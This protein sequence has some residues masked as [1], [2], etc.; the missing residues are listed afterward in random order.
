VTV[1]APRTGY[2]RAEL[3]SDAV[4]HAVGLVMVLAAVPVL[5]TLATVLRGDAAA[6]T[7]AAI[8]GAALV[9]MIAFSAAYN[10]LGQHRWTG[11]LQR[12]D[13]SAIYVK[14]A[15]TY[16]PF[17]ILPGDGGQA[18]WLLAGLWGAALAG[19]GLKVISPLRWRWLALGL[20]LAMGWAGALAGAEFLAALP[21]GVLVLV[22]TGGGLYTLGVVFYLFDRL[23]YHY[24][25]WHVLVLVASIMFYAAVTLHLVKGG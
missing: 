1:L 10:T 9:M 12:L 23:P 13:H 4:V 19:V 11:L 25:I 5:I 21:P 22:A 6:V 24:T 3:I 14:I 16:T 17:L 20:Y 2:S 7:A 18:G 15:G 8:Y